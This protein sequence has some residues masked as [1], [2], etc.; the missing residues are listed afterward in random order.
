MNRLEADIDSWVRFAYGEQ[1]YLYCTTNEVGEGYIKKLTV[2]IQFVEDF[3]QML[4]RSCYLNDHIKSRRYYHDLFEL[5]TI[6]VQLKIL[7]AFDC[8]WDKA[9]RIIHN[10]CMDNRLSND[11]FTK[12]AIVTVCMRTDISQKELE[13]SPMVIGCITHSTL[14]EY[15]NLLSVDGQ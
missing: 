11:E 8:D 13:H 2:L 14:V 7:V 4:S 5:R 3:A 10:V 15:D 9:T 1:N 12:Q 6:L